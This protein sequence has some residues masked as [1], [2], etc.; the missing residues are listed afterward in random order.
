[1]YNVL[2]KLRNGEALTAKEKKIHGDGLVSVLRQ[3]HDDLD[4]A[5]FEAY[6]W[7]A[8]LS[9]DET[10]ERLIALNSERAEEE[11]RG[12]V[13]WLRPE[14][15]NPA[16]TAVTVQTE[17][18]VA[19][20]STEPAQPKKANWPKEMPKQIAAIRDLVSTDGGAQKVWSVDLAAAAFKG[21]RKKEVESILESLAALGLLIA[22]DTSEGKRWRAVA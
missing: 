13:R 1:M 10:L 3:I 7:P 11:R 14:F 6:G 20:S 15:Q 8:T 16:G 17:M 18:A 5:V 12:I 4:A 21:S 22:F 2:E 9:D 19:G